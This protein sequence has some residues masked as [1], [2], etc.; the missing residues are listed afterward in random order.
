[1]TKLLD[2]RRIHEEERVKLSWKD[3]LAEM[4][5][6]NATNKLKFSNMDLTPRYNTPVME[7]VI[8]LRAERLAMHHHTPDTSDDE[9]VFEELTKLSLIPGQARVKKPYLCCISMVTQLI[10]LE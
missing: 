10:L 2:I 4:N 9:N 6:R 7:E 5:K 3:Q 8:A 1:M